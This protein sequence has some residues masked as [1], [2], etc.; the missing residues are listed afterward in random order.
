MPLT[1]V[2]ITDNVLCSRLQIMRMG[3]QI[4]VRTALSPH[5]GWFSQ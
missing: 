2:T 5:S 3:I 4:R 1:D